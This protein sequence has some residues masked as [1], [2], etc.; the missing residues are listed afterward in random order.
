[1]KNIIQK[2]LGLAGLVGL[3]AGCTYPD[4]QTNHTANGALIGGASGAAIGA[5]ADRRAPGVGALIGGA[6]GLFAGGLVGHS[7]DEDARYRTPPP[8]PPPPPP[9]YA[10]VPAAPPP[11]I[12]DIK[13]MSHSGVSDDMIIGQ[14]N[15]SRAVYN[16][17]ANAILDLNNSGVSQRVISYMINTSSSAVTQ[18]PP[19]PASEVVVVAPGPDYAWVDGEWVWSGGAWVWVGGRWVMPPH[20]HA[21]W[22]APRWERGRYGWHREPGHWR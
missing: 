7:M 9:A 10:P 12:A 18:A 2:C 13:A 21:F 17:D 5:L 3:L 4:G 8:P 1:M 22:V 20:P 6:A 16:L 11:S 15:N 14:I 19:P